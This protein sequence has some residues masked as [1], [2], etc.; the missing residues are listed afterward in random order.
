MIFDCKKIEVIH[1]R[2]NTKASETD[3]S[4]VCHT[5]SDMNDLLLSSYFVKQEM[6]EMKNKYNHRDNENNQK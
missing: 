1:A 6:A 5:K 4:D 3:D 2:Y